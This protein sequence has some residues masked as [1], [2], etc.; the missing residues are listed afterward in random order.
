MEKIHD[1]GYLYMNGMYEDR[2]GIVYEGEMVRALKTITS[3]VS[4]HL[5]RIADA[6]DEIALGLNYLRRLEN[7]AVRK[8]GVG[9]YV[10]KY[11]TDQ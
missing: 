2:D 11:K 1:Q 4:V 9:E 6:L 10:K 7:D 3:E 8:D 5:P